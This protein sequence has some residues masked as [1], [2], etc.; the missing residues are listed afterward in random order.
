MLW[1][2]DETATEL[3][4]AKTSGRIQVCMYIAHDMYN[5]I[6][7]M[8]Y[9]VDTGGIEESVLISE[10]SRFQ[11]LYIYMY[12]LHTNRVLEISSQVCPVYQGVLI[13]E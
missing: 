12:I 1:Y 8:V 11:G 7:Y 10:V 13:S 4:R 2:W 9:T 5:T 6:M 3:N